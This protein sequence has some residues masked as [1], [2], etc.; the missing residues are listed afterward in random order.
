AWYG[1]AYLAWRQ[2][3][4]DAT[5]QALDKARE[6]GMNSPEIAGLSIALAIKKKRYDE[7]L[8]QAEAAWS[9]WP[10]SLGVA[11]A[12]VEALQKAGQDQ[13]AVKFL[14]ERIRQWPD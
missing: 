7:A 10:Q 6:G 9:R 11:L 3:D 2:G 8:A 1:L 4:L 14:D 12:L 13:R 5:R